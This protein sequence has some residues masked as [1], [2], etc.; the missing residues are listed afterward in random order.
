VPSR[1]LEIG[2]I[3][4]LFDA[5]IFAMTT[6][7]ESVRILGLAMLIGGVVFYRYL[8]RAFFAD[9]DQLSIII[10][11]RIL[12]TVYIGAGGFLFTSAFLIVQSGT[13]ITDI[14][15]ILLAIAFASVFI[16]KSF[17]QLRYFDYL[18]MVLGLLFVTTISLTTHAAQES[19]LLP[20]F[21]NL[22]HLLVTVIWGGGLLYFLLIPWRQLQ[23]NPEDNG[24]RFWHVVNRFTNLT[25]V[26]IGVALLTGAVLTFIH[27]HSGAAFD[28]TQYGQAL[29]LK[30]GI[31][32]VLFV[33]IIAGLLKYIPALKQLLSG[34]NEQ[35]II[36]AINSYRILVSLKAFVVAI[37]FVVSS[38]TTTY[39]PPDAAPF[40]NPQSWNISVADVAL[41]VDMRPVAGSTNNARF[42]IFLPENSNIAGASQ[43]TFDLFMPDSNIGSF[44]NDAFQASSD[45]YLGEGTFAMPGDWRF[46][47][48]IMQPG[49]ILLTGSHDFELPKQ[50][51]QEDIKAYLSMQVIGFTSANIINFIIGV[52][53]VIIFCWFVWQS[54]IDAMPPWTIVAGF[55]GIAAG[56]YMML[57]VILVKTYPSTFWSN[58]VPYTAN[59]I[60]QGQ[61]H[62]NQQCADC[63]GDSGKGDGPWALEHNRQVLD[64]ASP[65]LDVHTDGEIFW[66]IT[67]GIPSLDMPDSENQLS[68]VQRWQVINFIRSIRHDIPAE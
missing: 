60:L 43:A 14:F 68:E 57:S 54:R 39:D 11:Q 32:V 7:L 38:V 65:H 1:E 13:Q 16:N 23:Q 52:L 9:S 41:R 20:I 63:H 55:T 34:K 22:L 21:N 26:I 66:W 62:F 50:P 12:V 5:G 6:F 18:I 17:N 59:N 15:N 61:Q 48:N 40:L 3:N 8:W 42:E 27:V 46:V 51:L 53:L 58:P 35:G 49:N 24:N 2:L 33:M 67:Y 4:Q 31:V 25:I 64:L 36:K 29:K 28:S 45:S 44:Q 37:I 30:L 56:F 19:G 47:I 10:W